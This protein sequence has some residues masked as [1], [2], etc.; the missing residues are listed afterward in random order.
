MKN[1]KLKQ[2][3]LKIV[4]SGVLAIVPLFPFPVFASE[5]TQIV[6][7]WN[8]GSQ[9]ANQFTVTNFCEGSGTSTSCEL[10]FTANNSYYGYL[11]FDGYN[12][13]TKWIGYKNVW[14]ADGY[15]AYRYSLYQN[16]VIQINKINVEGGY[17]KSSMDNLDL[18]DIIDLL[19]AIETDTTSI[20]NQMN[21]E[22]QRLQSIINNQIIQNGYLEIL[23]KLRQYQIP[24]ESIPFYLGVEQ[25]NFNLVEFVQYRYFQLPVYRV[26]SNAVIFRAWNN[27]SSNSIFIFGTTRNFSSASTF[28]QYFDLTDE[29]GNRPNIVEIKQLSVYANGFIIMRIVYQ[30]VSNS[31]YELKNISASADNF[32]PIFWAVMS[33]SAY[34]NL[35]TDFALNFGLTNQL[36][37]DLHIIAQGTQTS[38]SSASSTDQANDDLVTSS[39]SLFQFESSQNQNMNNALNQIDTNYD[40]GNKFGSKFLASADWVRT[41]FNV[42]TGN[43]PFGSVLSFSLLLGLALLIIGKVNK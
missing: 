37:D 10:R 23:T 38:Q 18:Q 4:L 9:Y 28:F 5:Q 1:E 24:F 39:D 2:K 16:G 8:W 3:L 22:L 34:K 6:P 27:M 33:N 31:N 26:P 30:P 15:G 29:N 11:S 20:D 17:L 21:T 41:Q 32:M 14:I 40:V 42:L 25:R 12:G 43:T 13:N 36:L 19:T 7:T 35:S